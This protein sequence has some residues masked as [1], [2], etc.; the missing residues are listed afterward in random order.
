MNEKK[1]FHE[2]PKSADFH[3]VVMTTYSFDFH[4]F[5]SQVL[6]VLKGKGITNVNI[7]ADT[8]MLDQ[9][10][11]FSTGHLKSLSTSYSINAI[12]CIGAFHPKVTLLAGENDVLLLQGSG[13]ITNGGHGKNHEVFSVFYANKENQEQLLLIQEAWKYINTLTSKIEGLSAEKLRWVS[14]NCN[15]LKNLEVENHKF[16]QIDGNYDAALVYNDE[17]SIWRQITQLLPKEEVRNIKIFSPFYDEKGTFVNQLS[18]YFS[19]SE[20]E[21]FLQPDKGIHPH[22]MDRNNKISFLSWN[23]TDRASAS[24]AKYDRKLHSKI[25]WFDTGESQYALFGSPNATIKAFGSENSRG[26]NDEF[27]VLIKVK[28]Q[29][30]FE[31][32]QLTGNYTSIK[33]Q[34]ITRIQSIEDEI[35]DE[36]AKNIRKIKVLGVDQDGKRITLFI[37]NQTT[38]QNVKVVF[39]NNW[40]ERLEDISCQLNTKKITVELNDY[41]NVKTV[42]FVQIVH[43]ND[44]PVSNK[45]IINRL[46]E[47]WNTNPSSENRRLMKLGSLIESGSSRV[48]DVINYFNDIRTVNTKPT[49]NS[50]AGVSLEDNGKKEI[51]SSISYQDAIKLDKDAK[52][53]QQIF[54]QHNSIKIWDAIENYF[55]QLVVSEEEADMDDEEEGEATTSRERKDTQ[56]RTAPISLNSEKVLQSRR[57]AIDKFLNNYLKGL[58]QAQSQV[59]Y[60]VGLIDMAMFLIVLKHLIEFTEREVVFRVDSETEEKIILFP[61]SGNL[62][63]LTSFS[64]AIL[65]LMGSFVNLLCKSSFMEVDDDYMSTKFSHYKTL[66][67]RT[68]IFCLSLIKENYKYHEKGSKWADLLAYNILRKFG[69]IEKGFEKNFEDFLKNCSIKQK[70]SGSLSLHI[71]EWMFRVDEIDKSKDLHITD[72]LGVCCIVKTIP[73][74]GPTKYLRLGRPGFE[75]NGETND[76]ILS[77]LLDYKSGELIQSLQKFKSNIIVKSVK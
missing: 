46:H 3:S 72:K 14:D 59:N 33:P 55:S 8:V 4:H 64:G 67:K 2:I 41:K 69:K 51:T 48:F 13:N 19:N 77:D 30:I 25:I 27:A 56:S 50:S 75:Y 61:L 17:T 47:L 58:Q 49:K 32:L 65:N 54:N 20:I 40:G 23:S 60:N 35:D 38:Y 11:G 1:L 22:R 68:S 45:Q 62:S 6:R 31:Q 53:H 26:V 7:F 66:V 10:I 37:K 34:E 44:I 70:E 74:N 63:E 71:E 9:S 21:A 28:D 52:K 73:P 57:K 36:Q 18:N 39:F 5:E 15:L 12:P 16:H 29:Q 43:E 24:V 76:F 42:S